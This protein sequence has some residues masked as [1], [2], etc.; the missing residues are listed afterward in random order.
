MCVLN[1]QIDGLI[2]D[3]AVILSTLYR[4]SPSSI[5]PLPPLSILSFLYRSSPSSINPLH[6]V[7]ATDRDEGNDGVVLFS[8]TSNLVSINEVTGVI[9]TATSFNYEE[10]Q[11]YNFTVIAR[12]WKDF[13]SNLHTCTPAH[14]HTLQRSLPLRLITCVPLHTLCIIA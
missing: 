6:Q 3:C 12:G 7:T 5:D 2:I 8:I 11:Q 14:L 9:T 4:S 1:E 10:Q 13:V